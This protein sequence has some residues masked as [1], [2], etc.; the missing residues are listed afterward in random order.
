LLLLEHG[1]DVAGWVFE[2]GDVRP[3]SAEN[4]ALVVVGV[5]VAL[6]VHAARGQFVDGRVDVVHLEV[7]DRVGSRRVVGLGID[8]RVA[9]TGEVQRQQ[10]VLLGCLQPERVGVELPRL[11][12]VVHGETAVGLGVRE[13]ASF[14]P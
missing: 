5:V 13:H 7:Q 4:A 8:Q 11:L 2:P 12:Q 14:S 6:E 1:Q 3:C 10:V 9:A